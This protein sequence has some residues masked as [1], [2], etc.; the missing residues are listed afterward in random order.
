M[1]AQHKK[2]FEFIGSRNLNTTPL[3]V[4]GLDGDSWDYMVEA[5]CNS[6]TGS[7]HHLYCRLNSDATTNYRRYVMKGVTSTAS[8][9]ASDTSLPEISELWTEGGK[10]AISRFTITGDSGGER[11]LNILNG[12]SSGVIVEKRSVYW[13]NTADNLTS[14]QFYTGSS[15]TSDITLRIYQ[16]PKQANLDNYDLVESVDFVASSS[17]IVFSGLDGDADEEYL[18]EWLGPNSFVDLL[19]N[20]DTSANYV[21]Q[22]LYNNNGSIASQNATKTKLDL[23]NRCSVKINSPSGRKRLITTSTGLIASPAQQYEMT[24]W[25]SNTAD[26]ITSMTATG[27]SSATGSVKL[28]KRKSNKTIDPVPMDTVVEYDIAGVDFSAGITITGIEGDRIDGAMK[29]EFVGVSSTFTEI[30]IRING[31]NGSNY[32]EQYLKGNNSTASSA[33]STKT[34]ANFLNSFTT[35]TA[36]SALYLYPASGQNRP[37]LTSNYGSISNALWFY[38]NWWNN[39]VDEI[40]SIDIY[41]TNTALY[42]GKI[43]VSLPRGTKQASPSFTVTTN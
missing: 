19:I 35:D 16:I 3:D 24:H 29:I 14:L 7:T 32:S 13:K 40:T 2:I 37:I 26:N 15:G 8:A 6:Y 38:A 43:R 20:N 31:D 36:M 34:Y 17:D 33:S 23:L 22:M 12:A 42:T 10:V 9:V 27:L 4:T 39:S 1:S 18:I 28:Y 21:R 25:W 11:Y 30:D 41:S 5:Q